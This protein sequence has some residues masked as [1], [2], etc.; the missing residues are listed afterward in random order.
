MLQAAPGYEVAKITIKLINSVAAVINRDP[1][2]S[3]FLK[4]IFLADYNVSL[5]EMIVPAA[6]LNQQIS[7]AGYEASGTRYCV[8]FPA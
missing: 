7:T 3:Q 8:R 1:E 5:A 6:D 2:T 4:L